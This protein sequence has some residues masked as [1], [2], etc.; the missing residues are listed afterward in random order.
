L[1]SS[2]SFGG[3]LYY[4]Y[5]SGNNSEANNDTVS[6]DNQDGEDD[7]GEDD[8]GENDDGENDDGEV[9]DGNKDEDED[10]DED[11]DEDE[12]NNGEKNYELEVVKGNDKDSNGNY[13]NGKYEIKKDGEN[14]YAHIFIDKTVSQSNKNKVSG[15]VIVGIRDVEMSKFEKIVIDREAISRGSKSGQDVHYYGIVDNLDNVNRGNMKNTDHE[16]T[17]KNSFYWSK[18]LTRK[19]EEFD[20]SDLEKPFDIVFGGQASSGGDRGIEVNVYKIHGVDKN[21]EKIT[22]FP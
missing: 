15:H 20:V 17:Y 10:G 5:S 12:D 13:K 18:S 11:E 7:N 14:K 9:D 2:S 16:N 8:N 21:G 19:E 6:T 4:S 1:L 3:A 22:L